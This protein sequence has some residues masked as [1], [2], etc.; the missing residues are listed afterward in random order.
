MFK[1]VLIANRGEIS[2]RIQKTLKK[3]GINSVAIYSIP[4]KS[5]LHVR[6]ADESFCVGPAL[7]SASY[8]NISKII[9]VALQNKVE[10]IHP[11]YGFLS[12]NVSFAEACQKNGLVFI[13][14]QPQHLTCFGLK[15][16]ARK[17]A[18]KF[19]VPCIPGTELLKSLLEAKSAALAVGYPIM[20]K[21]TAGGGG[22]GMRG[23]ENE[24]ELT[25]AWE[26]IERLSQANFGNSGI[27]L[28]KWVKRSRHIEVQAFGDGLGKVLILGDRDCSIQRRNQKIIEEAP[29]P[30]ISDIVRNKIHESA[31]RLLAGVNYLSAGTVEFLYNTENEEFYFLEVNTRLQVEHG[32]TEKIFNIDL[33]E[34]MVK[35]ASE[36]RQM[37]EV[38]SYPQAGHS[39]EIRVYAENP[40]MN[41]SPST[42]II[43]QFQPPQN[44]RID[45][46]IESGQQISS[47]YDPL[48][49]KYISYGGSREEA[50]Q[51]MIE[52]LDPLAL[53]GVETNIQYCQQILNHPHFKAGEIYTKFLE[54]F[55][56]T[57]PLIQVIEGGA[58]TTIQDLP[59]RIG[60]WGV[61]VPPSGP[62]DSKSFSLANQILGNSPQAPG[63][64]ITLTGPT[65]KFYWDC[66]CCLSGATIPGTIISASGEEQSV[67]LYEPFLVCS[68]D[69]L[70]LGKTG[71]SGIRSYLA[72][73]GGFKVPLYMNSASTFSLGGFGGY[74][75]KPLKIGDSL[76]LNPNTCEQLPT[77][78]SYSHIS[79]PIFTNF[80]EIGV[81]TGPHSTLDYFTAEDI[82][83]FLNTEW[84]VHFNSDRTGIRLEGP[85]PKFSRKDGGEAGLHPS[86][87]HDN[88]YAF[89][90]LD[91]TGDMPIFLGP[92]GP[93]LGGF[94]CPFTTAS[95]E[96]WKLGQLKAGD[97]VVLKLLGPIQNLE[98][99]KKTPSFSSAGEG[100]QNPIL[101]EYQSL[102]IRSQ[103]DSFLLIE[104]GE[105]ALNLQYRFRIHAIQSNL[106]NKNLPGILDFT[107]GVRSLQIHFN[108]EELSINT[109][110]KNICQSYSDTESIESATFPIRR[111]RLPLSWDDDSIHQVI[112]RYMTTVRGNA[113]W[114]P[115]NIEFIRRINGL[116]DIEEVKRIIFDAEYLVLGLGDV[117][118]GAPL[119]TPLD[120]RH[121]LVTT[122]YNPARTWTL[123]NV[124]GIGGAYMCI[125]GM[126]GPGGYQLFGRTIPVWNSFQAKPPFEAQKPW[127]LRN[128]D[129]IQFYPVSPEELNQIREDIL[130]GQSPISITSEEFSVSRYLN[131]LEMNKISIQTF[132][133]NQRQAFAEERENWKNESSLESNTVLSHS[134]KNQTFQDNLEAPENVFIQK[135]TLPGS[136]WKVKVQV[137][138][139][140]HKDQ[141]LIVLESMKM[142]FPLV[143]HS[144]GVIGRVLVQ[145][146]QTVASGD[147]LFWI[148]EPVDTI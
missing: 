57:S 140:I 113:P 19:Q 78:E 14:P 76:L 129:I 89:G 49:A 28:E 128:F 110:L 108:P 47:H 147:P 33:V 39:L 18:Q 91:I 106:E 99:N 35:L 64:E 22:I 73:K 121:R 136:I 17:L 100:R 146:G 60:Y 115:S 134:L 2:H 130:W 70:K 44:I 63:L 5:S 139:T 107:P 1:K 37:F 101:V 36:N 72:V 71:K 51:Q 15:H 119:A 8:L 143:A 133:E 75:G 114:C 135:S 42:G 82:S 52:A 105:M 125:Y 29:A 25:S 81:Y 92:D 122:K 6:E 26:V 27:Y 102:C 138:E 126:E 11:G 118:L 124:V 23:C 109:L 111:L 103:G 87:I 54:N 97:I 58:L 10:A 77:R 95:H 53:T 7:P 9:E 116:K 74:T 48:L 4:D 38:E 34:W 131:F 30:H 16:E 145:E 50:I 142:E 86:N 66:V 68:G 117:Y 79:I 144:T 93:S 132:Q 41:F 83:M 148:E 24:E 104:I 20:L 112:Q 88:A 12:E 59:G 32:V 3:M 69:I 45:T 120:P 123:P 127:L 46:W 98:Q 55:S 13:G 80:W 94:V 43:S 84:K 31:R 21:S 141:V 62:F 85:K 96:L 137:G 40:T 56:Y 67:K 90:T 61:G 65:L